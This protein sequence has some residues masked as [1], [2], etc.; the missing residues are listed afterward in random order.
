MNLPRRGI[1]LL[2]E[3][4]P[5][6]M[7]TQLP[8]GPDTR[9]PVPV[10]E[11]SFRCFLCDEPLTRADGASNQDT[12]EHVFPQWL[13]CYFAIGSHPISLRDPEGL[14]YDEFRIPACARRNNAYLSQFENR[15]KSA[16]EGGFDTFGKLR[17]SDIF[18]WCGKIYYGI[19]HRAVEP[20][21]LRKRPLTPLLD[22][23]YL[24]HF[25]FAK[26]LLQG[27]RK[28]VTIVGPLFPFSILLFRLRC[29]RDRGYYFNV[30]YTTQFV[31]MGLQLGS[32][33]IIMVGDD[34][35]ETERFFARSFGDLAEETLH[36]QQFWEIV[37][38][39]LYYSFTHPVA[40]SSSMIESPQDMTLWLMPRHEPGLPYDPHAEAYWIRQ[41]TAAPE[42]ESYLDRKCE[43]TLTVLTGPDEKFNEI[44]FIDESPPEGTA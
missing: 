10:E 20:R 9:K 36:P 29:G 2:S 5:A 12:D 21:D 43:H 11:P 39:A 32:V 40:T 13:Q 4:G 41:F 34:Y 6:G 1:F 16:L 15:I 28:R 19:V 25:S 22:H 37:G 30:R 24:E 44:E 35:G 38:R 17:K 7:P 27:F 18:L 3:A 14:T 31:G 33:G 8:K 42:G 26:L 23:D